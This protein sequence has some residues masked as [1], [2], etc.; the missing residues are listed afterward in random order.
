[1]VFVIAKNTLALA[2]ELTSLINN[3]QYTYIGLLRF[4]SVI[5]CFVFGI[6]FLVKT[7]RYFIAIKKDKVFIDALEGKYKSDVLPKTHIFTQRTISAILTCG[8]ISAFFS[9]DL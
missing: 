7:V 9:I 5:I 2:P 3:N 6:F 1:M 4:F 8:M